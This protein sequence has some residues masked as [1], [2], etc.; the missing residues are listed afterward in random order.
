[1]QPKSNFQ[2]DRNKLKRVV[3]KKIDLKSWFDG[4][5]E[6]ALRLRIK[7]RRVFMKGDLSWFTENQKKLLAKQGEE[8]DPFG[9]E[10]GGERSS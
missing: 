3:F 6:V 9:G 7:K 4:A 8:R 2:K 5:A 1:V 10:E